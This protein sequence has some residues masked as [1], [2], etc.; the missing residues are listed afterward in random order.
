MPGFDTRP[1]MADLAAFHDLLLIAVSALTTWVLSRGAA[2]WYRARWEEE[3]A[4]TRDLRLE[5]L[6]LRNVQ[7]ALMD[8]RDE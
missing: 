3:C 4:A 2:V 8:M 6:Q 5:I 7:S 1:L